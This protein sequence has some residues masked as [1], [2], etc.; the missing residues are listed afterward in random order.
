VEA[1]VVKMPPLL[2]VARITKSYGAMPVLVDVSLSVDAGERVGIVGINGVGKS[3]L[4]RIIAG[5]ERPDGGRIAIAPGA[6]LGYFS[7]EPPVI[8]DQTIGDTIAAAT[9]DLQ[10][11]AGR[12][13][14]LEDALARPDA[15]LGPSLDEYGT[16]QT[17]FLARGGYEIEHRIDSVLDGLGI[18]Y[19][20][21]QRTM[22]TLSGGE[23]ARVSLGAL[24]L[25]TPDVLLLDE[26]TS[27]LDGSALEWLEDYL[28][29]YAGGVLLVSHDRL[30]LN[31]TVSQIA[32]I[33]EFTRQMRHYGGD[34]DAYRQA[35][36]AERAR[37]EE[38]YERQQEEIRALRRRVRET[39]RQIAHNRPP[40]DNDKNIA[41]FK[42]ENV[43]HAISRN[44][45]AAEALLHQIEANPI[46]RPPK[47][48]TFRPRLETDRVRSATVIRAE[49]V[50]KRI[51]ER[52]LLRDI[53]FD[54]A[55]EAR[56][57]ITGPNGAGKTTL[58]RIMLGLEAPDSGT[59]TVGSTIKIGYLPQVPAFPDLTRSLEAVFRDHLEGGEEN[60]LGGVLGNGLFRLE[61][62]ERTVSQ[63]SAG[64]RQKLA[65]AGLIADRP[66]LLILDEPTSALS[67]DVLEAFEAA[68]W[69]FSG[70]V[71]A[72]SHDRWFIARFGSAVWR[73]EN[74]ILD[75]SAG[76]RQ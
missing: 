32:A 30:F 51:G 37:W 23:R 31:R 15:D 46:E 21:R 25:R 40:R 54:L 1:E 50:T 4:L 27:H 28:A 17:L 49:R 22:A 16:L 75:V 47:P 58:L 60:P 20:D 2:S 41:H 52:V 48:L 3:T 39:G 72:V 76:Q 70:P 59:V 64:Q 56:V 35:R 6:E 63:L 10:R 26:P 12:L 73:L 67:L 74:G 34:Y 57:V 65:I 18:G 24:L 5:L 29:H 42:G 66:N 38:D 8:P 44:V 9:G 45:R 62:M 11:I 36:A 53:S 61:D 69:G 68:I 43:A 71:V 14:A 19:L 33:D 7:Q 13:A 55:P